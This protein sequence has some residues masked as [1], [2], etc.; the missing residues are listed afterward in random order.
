MKIK[1]IGVSPDAGNGCVISILLADGA[2][3]TTEQRFTKGA[4]NSYIRALPAAVGQEFNPA[5][6]PDFIEADQGATV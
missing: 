6:F 1:S 4:A 2:R 3:L 5:K